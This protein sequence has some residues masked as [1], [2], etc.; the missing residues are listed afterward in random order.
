MT[1]TIR[2]AVPAD[3]D[4]MAEIH[5]RSWEAAYKDIMPMA[6]IQEKNVTRPALWRRV[7]TDE[8][9]TEYVMQADGKTVGF[10]GVAPPRDEDIGEDAYE[11]SGIYLH[12][13]YYRR[14]I[15]TQAMAFAFDKARGLGKTVITLWVFAENTNAVKFY[16]KCGLTPD[17]KTKTLDC[18]KPMASIRMRRDL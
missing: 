12:P 6:Y 11:V 10:I 14:G 4:D 16:E 13:D 3:A 5:M 7:I 15:G 1:V 9:T 8:N 18:G 2:L 17:G